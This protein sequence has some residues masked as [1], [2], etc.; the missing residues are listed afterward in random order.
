MAA[1]ILPS[2]LA[3]SRDQLL[4]AD[5]VVIRALARGSFSFGSP[6]LH[7]A[8][9]WK[10]GALW[11]LPL[12]LSALFEDF[13]YRGYLLFTLTSGIGFWPAA[14]VTSLLMGGAHYFNPGGHG[15]G[16]V[17]AFLYC[18]ATCVV[19]RRTGDLWMALGIHAA[20]SWGEV[21]FYGE[22]RRCRHVL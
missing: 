14:V 7:G 20:W 2:I 5:G 6:A 10:Y 18:L 4:F 11:T 1:R 17:T 12:F 21:F 9:I 22:A 8:D 16:P 13:L 3:G 19:I 15:L